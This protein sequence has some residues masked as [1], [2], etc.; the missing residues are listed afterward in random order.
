[1]LHLVK[2]IHKLLFVFFCITGWKPKRLFLFK[3]LTS[4]CPEAS[5]VK[6]SLKKRTSFWIL[7]FENCPE[8]IHSGFYVRQCPTL[9]LPSE[10]RWTTQ[11]LHV[12]VPPGWT[13]D[14]RLDLGSNLWD[15]FPDGSLARGQR[16]H[17][18]NTPSVQLKTS[19]SQLQQK[20]VLF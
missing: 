4:V 13:L 8:I 6:L 15:H 7:L 3:C 20:P 1:M 17:H 2:D 9:C 10:I 19:E 11:S 14:I 5:G 18:R 16:R 12:L